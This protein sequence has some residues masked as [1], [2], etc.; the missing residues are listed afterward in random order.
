MLVDTCVKRNLTSTGKCLGSLI[1]RY[2][3][4]TVVVVRTRNGRM[5]M[6]GEQGISLRLVSK[7]YPQSRLVGL[8]EPWII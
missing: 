4:V 6:E 7:H 2:K 5:I 1:F 3:R 8:R